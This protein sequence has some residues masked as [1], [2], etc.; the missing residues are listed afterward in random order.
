MPNG[1][2]SLSRPALNGCVTKS[3]HHVV[4]VVPRTHLSEEIIPTYGHA[5]STATTAHFGPMHRPKT[6]EAFRLVRAAS[7]MSAHGVVWRVCHVCPSPLVG[8][9]SSEGRVT[10]CGPP[11]DGVH[12]LTSCKQAPR[13]HNITA[14]N[15]FPTTT[16]YSNGFLQQAWPDLARACWWAPHQGG[17]FLIPGKSLVYINVCWRPRIKVIQCYGVHV[18][19]VSGQPVDFRSA[20]KNLP[21]GSRAEFGKGGK[22]G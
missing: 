5:S 1:F 18:E 4:S 6:L 19:L 14:L 3:N 11:F 17:L 2:T 20:A 10:I 9:V 22:G 16:M 21:D 15:I 13:M 12:L 7:N 8:V